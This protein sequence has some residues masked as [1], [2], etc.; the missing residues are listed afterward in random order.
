MKKQYEKLR[1]VQIVDRIFKAISI[2]IMII[3]AISL[4]VPLLWMLYSSV[5]PADEF[6]LFPSA[7]PKKVQFSN[8]LTVLQ[9]MEYKTTMEGIGE[10]RFGLGHMVMYSL[11]WSL[12]TPFIANFFQMI[13]SYVVC[14]YKFPGRNFIYALGIFLMILPIFGTGPAALRLNKALGLY[15]NLLGRIAISGSG[16]FYGFNFILM[17]GAWKGIPWDYAEAAFIDGSSNIRTFFQVM[18]PMMI[19]TFAVT[20]V[21]GFLG[22]WNDYMTFLTWL[23]SYPNLALGMY[24][25]QYN[26]KMYMVGTPVVL[27][28]FTIIAV[29][30]TILYLFSQKVIMAKLNVGGLKG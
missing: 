29:P 28:G 30:T 14:R 13:T 3:Y 7:L 21:L 19:P 24:M 16:A 6:L 12:S 22:T 5:K 2:T 4:I 9:K 26:A 27:A 25:F 17:Y 23:P 20:Y 8:F 15:D 1:P 10:V 18:M 11:I